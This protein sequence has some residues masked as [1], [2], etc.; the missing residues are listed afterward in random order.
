MKTLVTGATGFIGSTVVRELL[1]DGAEVRVTVRKDSDTTNI[2]GLDVEKTFAD[3]RDRESLKAAL[4]GCDT[5]Y[6][7]AAYF[8]HW[9]LNKDLFYQVNVDGTRNLLEEALAQGLEKVV[10]TSTANCMGAHGAGNYANEEAEFNEWE[11]GD[12]Y[13]I[14]KYLAEIEAKKICDKGL[15]MVIVNPTLVIGVRDIKPT[16][17]GKLIVDIVNREMPG[18]IDGATNIIDVQDVAR[19]HLL[20]AKKGRVG[21]RYIF[22]NDNVT[23]GDFFKLVAEVAGVKPPRLKL[24]Y[25]VALL[26]AYA[27]HAQARIT[28]K[29]PVVSLSQ[30]RIGKM[31]EHFDNSKAVNE[32]GLPLTPLRTTVENTIEWFMQNG[33]LKKQD[34]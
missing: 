1:K 9:S 34:R 20:A 30:V 33:Y 23:V 29:P 6:H 5:L 19:G 7:V 8:A 3:T 24:P 28:R 4:K 22:G 31:G 17:S 16:P 18:Y 27:F 11:T 25:P 2:D 14:S 13:A 26:L 32:L 12:H 15:P 21:E 10:Y